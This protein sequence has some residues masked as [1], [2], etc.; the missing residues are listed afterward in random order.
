MPTAPSSALRGRSKK[1]LS[2]QLLVD[3][4]L[5]RFEGL[6]AADHAAVDEEGRRAV[7]AGVVAHRDVLFDH[8]GILVRVETGIEPRGVEADLDRV[9]FEI[10]DAQPLLVR[11]QPIVV[12]PE[13]SLLVG[14][15]PGLGCVLGVLVVRQR[16]FAVNEMYPIAVGGEDLFEGRTDPLA[17]RS[18][19]VGK[20][21]HLHR[22]ARRSP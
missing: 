12:R 8:R 5:E 13:L 19:K 15:L 7:D 14:A 2:R 9:L 21:D 1:L 17:E 16:I 11:E 6:S 18:L 10:R 4:L 3:D 22:R 20:L